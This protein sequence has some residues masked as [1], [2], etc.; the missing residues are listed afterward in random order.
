MGYAEAGIK[1]LK[2]Q[3]GL[4]EFWDDSLQGVVGGE[5]ACPNWFSCYV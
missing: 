1:I 5:L 2:N 4:A 3:R